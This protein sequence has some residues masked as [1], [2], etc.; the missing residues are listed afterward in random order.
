MTLFSRNPARKT[1]PPRIIP[2]PWPTES[3][4]FRGRVG[5]YC[6][7]HVFAIDG[8]IQKS[9]NPITQWEGRERNEKL[10]KKLERMKS[11]SFLRPLGMGKVRVSP[12]AD[13]EGTTK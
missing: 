2:N 5:H 11:S 12:R 6:A 3:A 8:A 1:S 13:G 7:K 9:E 4:I 10:L